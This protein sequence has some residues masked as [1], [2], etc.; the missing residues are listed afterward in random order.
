MISGS[1]GAATRAVT[2]S[3]VCRVSIASASPSQN[4]SRDLR[5]YQLVSTSAWSRTCSHAPAM[6]WTSSAAVTPSTSAAVL[7]ST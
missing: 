4:R 3:T 7:A 1:S 5:T 6:S 2:S